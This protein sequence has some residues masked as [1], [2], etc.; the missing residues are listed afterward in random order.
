MTAPC[1]IKIA[2]YLKGGEGAEQGQ[3][4]NGSLVKYTKNILQNKNDYLLHFGGIYTANIN[5]L[6][7]FFLSFCLFAISWATP[8]A[9][10]GSQARGLIGPVA[11]SLHQSHSN[12]GSELHQ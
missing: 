3:S 8:T 7:F 4:I 11:A 12:R 9:Y 1:L 2:N 5:C 10:G 6:F